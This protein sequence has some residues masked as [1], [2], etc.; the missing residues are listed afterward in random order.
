[1]MELISAHAYAG[2][3]TT[4]ETCAILHHPIIGPFSKSN[5]IPLSCTISSV[6]IDAA[7]EQVF[8]FM[9]FFLNQFFC[10]H[11]QTQ[12]NLAAAMFTLA[13]ITRL[14]GTWHGHVHA[15][16]RTTVGTCDVILPQHLDMFFINS[17]FK[18]N[19]IELCSAIRSSVVDARAPV[20]LVLL[21]QSPNFVELGSVHACAGMR[22]TI[23]NC[24]AI[25]LQR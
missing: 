16:M 22:I 12:W 7:P 6:I 5:S 4:N 9:R 24:A 14:N 21:N 23:E 11:H 8:P 13:S 20:Y 1:M 19:P 15:G 3:R 10:I 2:M 18:S 17:P 25:L